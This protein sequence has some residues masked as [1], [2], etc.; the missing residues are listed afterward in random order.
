M[1]GIIHNALQ[2]PICISLH[3]YELVQIQIYISENI[4]QQLEFLTQPLQ[5]QQCNYVNCL[6]LS[7]GNKVI[8]MCLGIYLQLIPTCLYWLMPFG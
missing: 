1:H 6:N 7:H 3:E 8:I 2:V 5:L 4:K